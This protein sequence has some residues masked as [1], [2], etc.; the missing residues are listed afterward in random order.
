MQS[1]FKDHKIVHLH[2]DQT[3][4]NS[5]SMHSQF[6][7]NEGAILR[8]NV[9]A[10]P[11]QDLTKLLSRY[12]QGYDRFNGNSL[13]SVEASA[14][15]L[16]SPNDLSNHLTNLPRW[17]NRLM[18][19]DISSGSMMQLHHVPEASLVMRHPTPHC[20]ME[21]N[22]Q[23]RTFQTPMDWPASFN[24][25][26]LEPQRTSFYELE[27]TRRGLEPNWMLSTQLMSNWGHP[28][29]DLGFRVDPHLD[30]MMNS[31]GGGGF[32]GSNFNP[33][34]NSP[35][36]PET[37]WSSRYHPGSVYSTSPY[38]Q[39][40]PNPSFKESNVLNQDLMSFKDSLS[41]YLFDTKTEA[42]SG[43]DSMHSSMER[44]GSFNGYGMEESG[45]GNTLEF[46]DQLLPP[47]ESTSV[48]KTGGKTGK[49]SKEKATKKKSG[50]Q[51][52]GDGSENTGQHWLLK[53]LTSVSNKDD[54][55]DDC[56]IWS[57][58]P[59]ESFLLSTKNLLNRKYSDEDSKCGNNIRQMETDKIL[60]KTGLTFLDPNHDPDSIRKLYEFLSNSQSSNVAREDV[61]ELSFCVVGKPKVSIEELQKVCKAW[62]ASVPKQ[63][64]STKTPAIKD[65]QFRPSL[66]HWI[67][68]KHA[69]TF[70]R[71]KRGQRSIEISLQK[72]KR[73]HQLKDG[74]WSYVDT[75][76]KLQLD[77][78]VEA[79]V[80]KSTTGVSKR[81]TMEA[82][83]CLV[84]E[85]E[86]ELC[87]G[88]T[89]RFG[90]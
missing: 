40:V 52:N 14:S 25:S 58:E 22:H 84:N 10:E 17:T 20:Q 81:K 34:L 15:L 41:D 31:N 13:P 38:H 76:Q 79:N 72:D 30:R 6:G 37:L 90:F 57:M 88:K 82:Q 9:I 71:G 8:G 43:Q 78:S 73:F 64:N 4:Y 7:I 35:T 62:I 12:Q 32:Y 67:G 48:K 36:S 83:D 2:S 87:K 61:L 68:L 33:M 50:K 44:F 16:A 66:E 19:G 59:T 55:Q 5:E 80:K 42:K 47:V 89:P 29:T 46:M 45:T 39:F 28:G 60:K 86:H 1:F 51:V 49:K 24:S 54:Q 26:I 77:N 21:W 18:T 53:T 63:L 23:H 75:P 11:E 3:G 74:L 56:L 65:L 69:R 27:R 70:S 85:E